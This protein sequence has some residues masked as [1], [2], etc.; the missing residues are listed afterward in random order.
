M[1]SLAGAAEFSHFNALVDCES[2]TEHVTLNQLSLVQSNMLK[3]Q[4][5]TLS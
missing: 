2:T 1:T 3:Y 4:F 5:E